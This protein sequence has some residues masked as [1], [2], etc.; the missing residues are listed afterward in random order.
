MSDKD[1]IA[2]F[3][4]KNEVTKVPCLDDDDIGFPKDYRR[5]SKTYNE[6]NCNKFIKSVQGDGTNTRKAKKIN[7]GSILDKLSKVKPV[8]EIEAINKILLYKGKEIKVIDF[9]IFI[10]EKSGRSVLRYVA[11]DG[12]L[13]TVGKM[14]KLLQEKP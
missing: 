2:A 9:D 8:D 13:F 10:S 3:L 4:A 14:K 11:T 7:D 6:L 1:M 12:Y 5:G